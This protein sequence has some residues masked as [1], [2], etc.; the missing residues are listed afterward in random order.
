MRRP[1]STIN[2]TFELSPRLFE[3]SPRLFEL[4]PAPVRAVAEP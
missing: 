2:P 1:V 4:S 3:L